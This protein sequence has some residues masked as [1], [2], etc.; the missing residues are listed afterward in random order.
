MLLFADDVVFISATQ[1]IQLVGSEMSSNLH[2]LC[3]A[4]Y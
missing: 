3:N 4:S 1:V 2:T